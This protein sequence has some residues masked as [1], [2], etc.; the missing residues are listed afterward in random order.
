MSEVQ[1]QAHGIKETQELALGA[2]AIGFHVTKLM[3][4]GFQMADLGAFID[5][6]KSDPTFAQKLEAAY[7]GVEQIPAELKDMNIT[8]GLQ[9]G[10]VIVPAI[11][12]ELGSL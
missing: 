8:E 6:L 12:A 10:M 9:L 5:K 11:V 3:K 2:I 4:D 1:P 7:K